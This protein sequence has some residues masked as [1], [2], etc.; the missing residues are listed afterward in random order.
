MRKCGGRW[1][2]PL[3]TGPSEIFT[4]P[5]GLAYR[6]P[7]QGGPTRGDACRTRGYTSKRER[8]C[9]LGFL[10]EAYE[11][12]DG[13]VGFRCPAEPEDVYVG[14]GGKIDDTPGRRCLC[15]AL[16][17]NVGYAQVQR[18]G[19]VEPCLLTLGDDVASIGRFATSARP[20]YT[21]A[22]VLEVLLGD[23]TRPTN[24]PE[25]S[26]TAPRKPVRRPHQSAD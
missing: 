8:V 26:A 21:A 7:V 4:D 13:K 17:A 10:R 9:D 2:V 15:N 22:D 23:A 24:K 12:P 18:D 6:L 25:L 3:S 20:E 16:L 14:K 11:R 19:S 1:F 5:A